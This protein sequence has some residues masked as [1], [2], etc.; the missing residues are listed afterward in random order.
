MSQ[1]QQHGA[2]AGRHVL[3]ATGVRVDA[4]PMAL[5]EPTSLTVRSGERLLV[6]GEP[7]HGHTALAL[8]L[9]GRL[10]VDAGAVELDGKRSGRLL[11]RSVAL[12]D[13]PGVSEPDAVLPLGSVVAEEL[14]MAGLPTR[15]GAVGAFLAARGMEHLASFP[16]E[17]VPP[18][19]RVRVLAE[20]AAQRPGVVALVL[21]V[22]DRFGGDPRAWWGLAAELAAVGYAVVVT[23]T[24]ASALE[25][26]GAPWSHPWTG[27]APVALGSAHAVPPRAAARPPFEESLP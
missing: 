14:A 16:L 7:G 15:H 27:P 2:D 1:D 22:P 9:G 8:A 6:A 25:V 20:I 13:V 12:V 10:R 19:A 26:T 17:A 24:D 21:T 3:A 23:C 11:R 4:R 18:A 5:L